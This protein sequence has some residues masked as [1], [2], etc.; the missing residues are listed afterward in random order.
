M[1]GFG[2]AACWIAGFATAEAFLTN[3][4]K[5]VTMVAVM[6]AAAILFLGAEVFG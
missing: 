5:G 1:G 4:W 2:T 3:D 6:Y